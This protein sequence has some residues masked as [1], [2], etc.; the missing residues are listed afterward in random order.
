[1]TRHD[2]ALAARLYAPTSAFLAR[3]LP[4]MGHGLAGALFELARD[5]TPARCDEMLHRLQAAGHAVSRLRAQ[6]VSE[7]SEGGP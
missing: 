2:P 1:M 5:P 7:A 6:L 3:Q 4:D